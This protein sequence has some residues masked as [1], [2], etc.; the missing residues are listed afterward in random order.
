VAVVDGRAGEGADAAVAAAA[1]GWGRED[2]VQ[3][4]DDLQIQTKTEK[5]KKQQHCL[6]KLKIK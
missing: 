3:A 5:E 1:A 6:I 2:M 4:Y